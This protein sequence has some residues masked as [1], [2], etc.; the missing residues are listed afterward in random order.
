MNFAQW[1]MSE[2]IQLSAMADNVHISKYHFARDFEQFVGEPPYAYLSRLRLEYGARCLAFDPNRSIT[3]IA[4]DAGF[5]T[6]QSFSR[7]FS[8][9]FESSPKLFRAT[10]QWGFFRQAEYPGLEKTQYT[11]TIKRFPGFTKQNVQIEMRPGYRVAYVRNLGPYFGLDRG[12]TETALRLEHW[13]R[14][15]NLWQHKNNFIGLCPSNAQLTPGNLCIY[16]TCIPVGDSITEDDTVSIQYIPAGIYAVLR[17]PDLSYRV[18]EGWEWL[19]NEWLPSQNK[20]YAFH[21]S[22]ESYTLDTFK[23]SWFSF[24]VELC[25]RI[26]S[27]NLS[28]T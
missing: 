15:N 16:D 20:I 10:N 18:K 4:M 13:A 2:N 26:R 19:T 23:R 3:Q 8:K 28:Q 21:S 6:L 1:N 17:S 12:I 5:S 24:D 14:R 7:A 11:R 9:H 27:A 25:M 22:Y